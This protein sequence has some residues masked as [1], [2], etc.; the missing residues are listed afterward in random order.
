[1]EA[2]KRRVGPSDGGMPKQVERTV[3]RLSIK[4][5]SV[6]RRSGYRISGRSV[7]SAPSVVGKVTC[8]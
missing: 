1:M 7:T 3:G 6:W 2:G 5:P 4:G 8:C